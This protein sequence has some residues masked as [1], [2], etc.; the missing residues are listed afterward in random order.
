MQSTDH[1][2]LV[3]G[4]MNELAPAARNKHQPV[5]QLDTLRRYLS[6]RPHP[7]RDKYLQS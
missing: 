6:A 3:S 5:E 7:N 1:R 2:L 4:V